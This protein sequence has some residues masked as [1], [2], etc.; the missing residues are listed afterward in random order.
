MLGFDMNAGPTFGSEVEFPNAETLEVL[1]VDAITYY[2]KDGKVYFAI[3]KE[4]LTY[5][6]QA[7]LEMNLPRSSTPCWRSI[8]AWG[9]KRPTITMPSRSSTRSRTALRR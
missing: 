7:E 5:I 8:R 6:G 2:T 3:D 4:Y 1:P 9:S